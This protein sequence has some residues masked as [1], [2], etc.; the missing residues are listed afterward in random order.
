MYQRPGNRSLTMWEIRKYSKEKEEKW[1]EFV[2]NSRNSTFL[3]NRDYMD[4]HSDRITD[5]SLMA[6]RAGKLKAV[7]PA[8]I[9][10]RTLCSHQGLTYGGWVLAPEGLDTGEIFELWK[11]WLGWC[12]ENGIEQIDYKPLPYIYAERPSEED[13]Y[14]LYLCGAKPI[15]ANI[16][17]VIDLESNP[18]MD[19]LQRRHLKKAGEQFY[20]IAITGKEEQGYAEFYAMLSECLRQRHEATPVHTAAELRRLME[21]HPEN[22]RVFCSCNEEKEQI[23]AGVCIYET[24]MTAHCQYIATTEEGRALNALTPLFATLIDYYEEEGFRYFDF[25]TSNED[26]GR[27]LN[28]GLNRQKTSY[29]GSGVAYS[30]YE[31]NVSYALESMPNELWPRT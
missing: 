20:V 15:A 18:G 17:T 25:G 10:G 30:R 4:Y 22:I 29:G 19:K 3:F 8:N 1:N 27:K 9:S 16:A 11:T 14:M 28:V 2:E 6:Y 7:L 26:G 21:K 23:M 31:I 5:C 12:E 13:R 24:G